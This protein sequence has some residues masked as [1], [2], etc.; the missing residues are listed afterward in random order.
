MRPIGFST[1]ALAKGD[2][3]C[4][5]QLQRGVAEIN[6]VELS[7]LRAHELK[8]LIEALSTLELSH[9]RYVSFHAPSKLGALGEETVVKLLL[10]LPSNWPIVVHPEIITTYDLWATLGSRL[11]LENMDNRKAGGRTVAELKG[12]FELLP[13]ATFCLDVGHA[14]Q[15]D[16]TMSLA[17]L[18]LREFGDRLKQVHVSDVGATGEHMPVGLM[19]RVAFSRLAAHIPA[20]CPLIIESVIASAALIARE[21][22]AVTTAFEKWVSIETLHDAEVAHEYQPG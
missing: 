1:G 6:A 12:L 7:A 22:A 11:C 10:S 16:P 9:F 2:F 21:L 5:L 19:A 20:S 4:G 15:I 18:M 3:A 13:E 17:I 14:K 8:P